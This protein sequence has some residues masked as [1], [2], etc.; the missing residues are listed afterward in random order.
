MAGGGEFG[1]M[2]HLAGRFFGALSPAG[3]PAADEEWALGM[4]L[5]GERD[6]W[7]RMSGP[8]RRHAVGVAREAQRL[9]G[10]PEGERREFVAAALL[11]DVGKLDGG[12]GTFARV[13]VTLG[14]MALGRRRL[15]AMGAS[16]RPASVLGRVSAYLQHDRRGGALLREAGSDMFT[17]AWAQEHHMPPEKWSVSRPLG[18]ALKQADGD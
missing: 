11:H 14:A 10:A 2:V 15:V 9:A 4:L 6:L 16:R 13:A 7:A 8:D 12:L 5:P 18:T 17:V 1:S 3:P